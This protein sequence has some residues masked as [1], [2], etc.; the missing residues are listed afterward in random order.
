MVVRA[1]AVSI[2]FVH[3][4]LLSSYSGCHLNTP[5]GGFPSNSFEVFTMARKP[6]FHSSKLSKAENATVNKMIKRS[7]LNGRRTGLKAAFASIRPGSRNK[8][9]VSR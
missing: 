1:S 7:W 8:K 5:E 9:G 6:K 3:L 4:C 2:G